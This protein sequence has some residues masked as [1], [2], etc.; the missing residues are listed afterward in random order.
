MLKAG[1][2]LYFNIVFFGDM[3]SFFFL[4]T[5]KV[6]FIKIA[7]KIFSNLRQIFIFANYE[8]QPKTNDVEGII[9]H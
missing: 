2:Q 4:L 9:K 7:T 5:V 3:F 6:Y 1:V 8:K